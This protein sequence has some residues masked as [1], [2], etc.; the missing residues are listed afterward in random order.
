V[1]SDQRPRRSRDYMTAQEAAEYLR[2]STATVYKLLRTGRLK[3]VKTKRDWRL[4]H[5]A[6]LA[7][8]DDRSRSGSQLGRRHGFS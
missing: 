5:S 6:V 2:I 4:S 3:G 1:K 7:L 8:G